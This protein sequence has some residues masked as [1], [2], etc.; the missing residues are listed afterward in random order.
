MRALALL[1]FDELLKQVCDDAAEGDSEAVVIGFF[2]EPLPE[3]GRE[4]EVD[5][6]V[7]SHY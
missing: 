7:S 5:G 2:L 1:F 6:L 4:G 3:I